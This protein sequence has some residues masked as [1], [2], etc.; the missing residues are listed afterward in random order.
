MNEK[1]EIGGSFLQC[2]YIRYTPPS[3]KTKLYAFTS[4]YLF[5]LRR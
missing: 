2:D 4:F 5:S 3:L 1:Y